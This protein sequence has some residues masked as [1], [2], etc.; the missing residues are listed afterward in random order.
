MRVSAWILCLTTVCCAVDASAIRIVLTNDDGYRTTNIQTL[1][2]ALVQAGHDVI[3]S[4]PKKQQSGTSGRVEAIKVVEVGTSGNQYHVDSTPVG[5]VLHGLDV[6]AMRRWG[7]FPD[8][9][10]S[11]P[12]T[13]SNLGLMTPHSGTVG[14][15][16]TAINKG[17]PA[18]A[19]SAD[20]SDHHTA[21][22]VA[23]LVL[24]L[25][26]E[27]VE[28][29]RPLLPPNTGLNVNLPAV[30]NGQTAED[31]SFVMTTVGVAAPGGLVFV[32][33]LSQSPFLVY[34]VTQQLL[35]LGLPEDLAP[36]ILPGILAW[37]EGPGTGFEVPYTIAGYPQESGERSE[38]MVFM[39][40]SK[41]TIS[42]IEGT[43]QADWVSDAQVQ[44][45]LRDLVDLGPGDP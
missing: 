27:L 37:F 16:V 19:V 31:Y 12:N 14:A 18:L 9:V 29:G 2:T 28:S 5:A 21:E 32:E 23:N 17:V 45:R 42:V 6:A 34:M 33:D 25:V 43:Y 39:D 4:A 11:G 24:Q 1:F 3:L 41:V 8:L 7:E 15:A 35:D 10:I 36:F 26:Q 40:G 44:E 38:G 30:G 20:G 22:V 13:G